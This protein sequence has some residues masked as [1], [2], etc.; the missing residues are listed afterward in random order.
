MTTRH[1]NRIALNLC[2]A[3][4]LCLFFPSCQVTKETMKAPVERKHTYAT[5]FDRTWNALIKVLS[6][7]GYPFK[8]MEKSSGILQTD[9]MN[10][11]QESAYA[12]STTKKQSFGATY[13]GGTI[14]LKF[15]V[16]SADSVT[17]VQITPYIQA[18]FY[19]YK[20]LANVN[21]NHVL[22][23]NGTLEK[24][25]FDKIQAQLK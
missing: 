13:Q 25:L 3:L 2:A 1:A 9:N 22:E 7:D 21:E 16:Q 18:T 14:N 4:L 11:E 23:S 6:D 15:F 24:S 10:L 17:T 19:V 20:V 12:Y 8:I 5:S